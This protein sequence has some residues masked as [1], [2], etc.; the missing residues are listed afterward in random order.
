MGSN[1]I[2]VDWFRARTESLDR[3]RTFFSQN[4][5]QTKRFR[6]LKSPLAT[7]RSIPKAPKIILVVLHAKSTMTLQVHPCMRAENIASQRVSE[8][9]GALQQSFVT[10][11]ARKE[12]AEACLSIGQA[13]M[14]GIGIRFLSFVP[15]RPSSLAG[16][17][18]CL[19]RKDVIA[20]RFFGSFE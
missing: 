13:I 6:T 2:Q 20:L 4:A 16:W 19:L 12:A 3:S 15:R 14:P 9:R 10:W 17:L 11:Q 18:L 5:S 7:L 1:G 8:S